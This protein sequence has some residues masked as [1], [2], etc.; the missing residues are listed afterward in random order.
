MMPLEFPPSHVTA[1]AYAA[2][3]AHSSATACAG[4]R[5]TAPQPNTVLSGR[6]R[7]GF[8]PPATT[9]ASIAGLSRRGTA[10][11]EQS[12]NF[13]CAV[14]LEFQHLDA[15]ASA[16]LTQLEIASARNLE[17]GPI[18]R[19]RHTDQGPRRN[20]TRQLSLWRAEA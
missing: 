6:R 1:L 15:E 11:H 14:R 5:P 3:L 2:T 4:G 17:Q 8:A 10:E 13:E 12:V 19:R 7:A 18:I 9:A 20:T 16:Q